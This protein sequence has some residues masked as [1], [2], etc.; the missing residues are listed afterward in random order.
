M[1]HRLAAP[2]PRGS[3]VAVS[4]LAP[5]FAAA[6]SA[7][8]RQPQNRDLIDRLTRAGV[9]MAEAFDAAA[10]PLKGQEFVVTGTLTHFSRDEARARIRA[11]GGAAKSDVTKKTNY[12]VL[13]ANPGSKLAKAQKLGVPQIDEDE[14]IKILA[15]RG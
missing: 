4:T 14:F 5:L 3:Q 1:L 13:G 7:Y 10:Q 2:T 9:K 8:F 6:I 15:A 11:L 12:L